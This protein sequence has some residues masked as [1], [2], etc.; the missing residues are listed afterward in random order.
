MSDSNV[1]NAIFVVLHG[2]VI[3][4]FREDFNLKV[5]A[6]KISFCKLTYTIGP[7]ECGRNRPGFGCPTVYSKLR[8]IQYYRVLNIINLKLYIFYNVL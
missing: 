7:S 8:G 5:V 6:K 3:M 4:H 2:L 1:K